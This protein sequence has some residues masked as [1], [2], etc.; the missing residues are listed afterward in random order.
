[1][2]NNA[3]Q[4]PKVENN[5]AFGKQ[6]S[7]RDCSAGEQHAEYRQTMA[8]YIAT[9]LLVHI[10]DLSAVEYIVLSEIVWAQCASDDFA[11][12]VR[13]TDLHE[14]VMSN[15]SLRL[16]HK[17]LRETLNSLDAKGRL[18]IA[19]RSGGRIEIEIHRDLMADAKGQAHGLC[20]R[21]HS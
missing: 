21:W 16:G 4:L 10:F 8:S 18:T 20:M 15:H 13:F 5:L 1:M 6:T 2:V 11:V 19:K 14:L 17:S 9:Q 7:G 12:G 3:N